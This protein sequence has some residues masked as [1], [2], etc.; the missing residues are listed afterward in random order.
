MNRLYSAGLTT[1]ALLGLIVAAFVVALQP[2]GA[3]VVE[4]I[5]LDPESGPPG[6]IV[7]ATGV[8]WDPGDFIQVRWDDT[9]VVLGDVT[10]DEEG[11]FSLELT[12]PEDA[13][14]EVH[15]LR[16]YY[17][18]STPCL[19]PC[20]GDFD[21]LEFVVT[22]PGTPTETVTP[23][24]DP[25]ATVTETGTA[26]ETTTPTETVAPTATNTPVAT[27]TPSPT[28]TSTVAPTST[29]TRTPTVRPTATRGTGTPASLPKTGSGGNLDRQT[30][31][32]NWLVL[33]AALGILG[34]AG[35][36]WA[37]LHYA[38]NGSGRQE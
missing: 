28:N 31:G 6:T 18:N 37:T 15:E 27:N 11:G 29:V 36:A 22:Q 34:V 4:P 26:T 3:Q 33:M 9:D 35:A 5:V 10:V 23:T 20:T 25:S 17:G 14:L 30:T 7:T 19:E 8:D 32:W 2:A 1:F 16:F 21:A 12:I 24:T 38:K 13:T